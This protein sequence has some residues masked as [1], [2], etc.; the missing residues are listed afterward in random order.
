MKSDDHFVPSSVDYESPTVKAVILY[1]E[2][3]SYI[4]RLEHTDV[5]ILL[6]KNNR[7]CV[8]VVFRFPGLL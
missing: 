3:V 2:D 6:V 5:A 7:M 1:V 4:Y 8:C